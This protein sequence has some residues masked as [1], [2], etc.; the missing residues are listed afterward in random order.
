MKLPDV[1]AKT[2]DDARE[3]LEPDSDRGRAVRV[4]GVLAW[5]LGSADQETGV[6]VSLDLLLQIE[7]RGV[8]SVA[9]ELTCE[10]RLRAGHRAEVEAPL[11]E[12]PSGTRMVVPEEFARP[13]R[14]PVRM[15]EVRAKIL[16]TLADGVERKTSWV[17]EQVH[18]VRPNVTAHT[19]RSNL[20]RMV[21][22]N[23]IEKKGWGIYARVAG[24]KVA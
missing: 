15:G 18:R 4:L 17:I 6:A 10:M 2:L 7:R 12:R 22:R 20:S 23:E 14:R 21:E 5:F 8:A 9:R 1:L 11:E 19:I 3:G 13:V 16:E 24:R